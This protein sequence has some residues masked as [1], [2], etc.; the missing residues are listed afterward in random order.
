[1][2]KV[3][4]LV[5]KSKS[6]GLLDGEQ[7][8]S[9][10]WAEEL[11]VPYELFVDSGCEVDIATVDGE[12]PVPDEGSMTAAV[13]ART[14]PAGSPD[15]DE[16]N[17][18][19]YREVIR[20]LDALRH[21]LNVAAMTRKQLAEYDGVYICGGHGAMDDMPH[22]AGMTRLVRWVLD[23]DKPLSAVCHGLSAV[24]PVRDSHGRWPLEGYELT[25]FS[26]EEELVTE[27]AG[28][29]PFVLQVELERLGS[30]YRK[31]QAIWDACVVEDRN[32][33][34]GQNPYSSAPLAKAFLARVAATASRGA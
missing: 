19:H 21:P 34:T 20:S 6:L 28:R 30:R 5:T 14:R 15:R 13:V 27:M 22:D 2:T 16:E 17:V 12:V 4:V 7:C 29:L 10:F 9:G 8:D 24:L 3:L 31:A 1:M 26:H 18:E 32:L 33:V 11:V 23:L 25:A